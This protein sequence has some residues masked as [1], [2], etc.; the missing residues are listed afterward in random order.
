MWEMIWDHQ[1]V[2]ITQFCVFLLNLPHSKLLAGFWASQD[3]LFPGGRPPQH[4]TPPAPDP[5]SSRPSAVMKPAPSVSVNEHIDAARSGFDLRVTS[6]TGEPMAYTWRSL[7]A[8]ACVSKQS[9][10]HFACV[11]S[12]VLHGR[13]GWCACLPPTTCGFLRRRQRKS[14]KRARR[15]K[16]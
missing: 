4:Q 8:C 15:I 2:T 5:P 7:P 10:S 6:R 1:Q 11:M 3:W 14:W 16:E 9:G 13:K 12:F